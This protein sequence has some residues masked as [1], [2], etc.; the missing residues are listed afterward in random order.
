MKAHNT[1]GLELH[2][3]QVNAEG[4]PAF[5]VQDS[6][7]LELDGVST[8]QPLAGSPVIRLDRCP[9]AIMRNSRAFAGTGTFL[10]VAPGELK[11]IVLQG[12]VLNGARRATEEEVAPEPTYEPATE[13]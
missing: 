9:D 12:N 4:G 11:G 1:R 5:L 2:H 7:E 10:S 6:Q 8:R 3:V 13:D